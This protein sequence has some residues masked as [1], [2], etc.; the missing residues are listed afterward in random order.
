[1]N[2]QQPLIVIIGG[3]HNLEITINFVKYLYS[4]IKAIKDLKYIIIPTDK[5]QPLDGLSAY[6]FFI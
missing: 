1:M 6:N 5:V 2:N 3:F 4:Q